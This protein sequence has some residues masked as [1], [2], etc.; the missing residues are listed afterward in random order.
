MTNAFYIDIIPP[1]GEIRHI[2]LLSES[3]LVGR[4]PRRCNVVMVDGRI[5]RI[6]L[7]I[8]RH[9]DTG[10]TVTDMFSAHG[11]TLDGRPLPPG[12]PFN[13]LIEQVIQ[14]GNTRLILRYGEIESPPPTA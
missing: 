8:Q 14:M 12:V 7:R 13:W 1:E 5:S 2:P 10:V 11:S 6:H 4:S 3:L 9:P